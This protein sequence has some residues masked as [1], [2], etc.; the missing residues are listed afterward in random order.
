MCHTAGMATTRF[1]PRMGPA[2]V[3]NGAELRVYDEL[4]GWGVPAADYIDQLDELRDV[5]ELTVRINSPGGSVFEGI[6]LYNA[7][8]NHPAAVHVYVD[9]LAASAASFV[10]MA[11]DTITMRRGSQMMI[12]DALAITL[13]NEAD[14]RQMAD[15]LAKQSDNIADIY[16]ARTGESRAVWRKRMRAETWYLAGEAVDAGLADRT[17][18]DGAEVDQDPDAMQNLWRQWFGNRAA[19][20]LFVPTTDTRDGTTTADDGDALDAFMREFDMAPTVREG[21][22]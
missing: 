21:E 3:R 4:G 5:A 12:H 13:G 7:L 8:R 15:L 22:R 16:A 9:A 18:D 6:A 17:D 2:D 14:H 20:D 11:G 1:R 19:R 10:A